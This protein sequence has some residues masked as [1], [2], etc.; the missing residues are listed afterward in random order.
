MLWQKNVRVADWV[1]RFTVGEDYRWDTLLLP[2]DIEATRAHAEGLG[3]I[4]I[5]SQDELA[6]VETG[7]ERL[8]EKV[9]DGEIGVRP[10]DED[11]HTVIE[12]YLTREIGETGKKIHTGRSRNDQVLAALRLFLREGIRSAGAG[13][14]NLVESLIRL[15]EENR[16]AIMPG[17]THY[18]RAMP[19]TAASWALGYA[20]LLLSDLETLRFAHGR[21]N[22]SPLGSAAGYGAPFLE[23]DRAGVAAGLGFEEVQLHVASVQLSRGKLELQAV[24]AFVQTAATLNRIASD[25]V[26][27]NT[28]EYGFVKLPAAYCTGSS[29]MPQKQN[30]DVL[31]LVRAHYHRLVAEMSVL[32]TLPANLPS[33][34]HRD[35]Q[36]T[37]EAAMRSVLLTNDLLEAMNR[38]MPGV[39]FQADRMREACS[40]DLFATAEALERVRAGVPFRDAYR[41]AAEHLDGL[42]A[43]DPDAAL[44]S[45]RVDGFPGRERP[46]L[47]RKKLEAGAGWLGD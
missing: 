10:E 7:L 42:Q 31:E 15:A 30:P 11:C 32:L 22:T 19:T 29:I 16:A 45:Y 44:A 34:Y 33:G 36:L 23:L 1:T 46:D 17:Y 37:K 2:Y 4:G 9:R 13:A 28:A 38:L 39:S 27:F 21:V 12:E 24:H 40:P 20:E 6:A 5:L 35:L 18:Q 3:R 47:V 43:P 14:R 41:Q 8:E 26:L 25:L